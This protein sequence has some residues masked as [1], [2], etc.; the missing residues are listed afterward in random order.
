MEYLQKNATESLAVGFDGRM[1]TATMAEEIESIKNISVIS[2]VD[3]VG[4]IWENRPLMCCK[5][6]WNLSLEYCGKTRAHKLGDI[7]E[8]MK[9]KDRIGIAAMYSVIPMFLGVLK[10]IV[11]MLLMILVFTSSIS[12]VV[13]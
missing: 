12:E 5:P 4:E 6:V 11:D 1:M 10:I 7:R 13:K 3:L 9:N 8:E 2:D